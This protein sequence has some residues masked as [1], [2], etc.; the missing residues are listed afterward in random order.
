L[1]FCFYFNILLSN[2]TI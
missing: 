2:V 1:K